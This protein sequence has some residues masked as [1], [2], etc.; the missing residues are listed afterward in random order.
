M[1][2]TIEKFL[3]WLDKS[4]ARLLNFAVRYRISAMLFCLFIFLGTLFLAKDVKTEFLAAADNDQIAMTVE[5]P[6]GARVELSRKVAF[7]ITEIMKQKY[8][9]L[10]TITYTVGQADDDDAYQA[11]QNNSDNLIS[12]RM[13]A[14]PAN[15]RDRSIFLISD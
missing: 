1:Y 6:A 2:A 4:Y 12:F 9:E 5:L 10:E 14:T 13:K 11:T 15:E 8:P 7:N 3:D